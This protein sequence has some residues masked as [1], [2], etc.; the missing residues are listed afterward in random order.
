[1]KKTY[2]AIRIEMLLVDAADVIAT[3][4]FYGEEHEFETEETT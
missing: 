1:M 2:E 4:G 3:S